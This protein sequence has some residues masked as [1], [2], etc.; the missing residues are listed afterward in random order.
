MRLYS[1][2]SSTDK[3]TLFQ[4]KNAINRS[5]VP[6]DPQKNVKATEDF[7]E[8]DLVG[9]IVAAAKEILATQQLMLQEVSHKIA[10]KFVRILCTEQ[11]VITDKKYLYAC[12][13]ITLGLLWY[14]YRDATR[15]GD[16][17]RIVLIW[18][19]LLMI[20][21]ACKRINYSKEAAILLFQNHFLFSERKAAQLKYS[22]FINVHGRPGCNISSDLFMEH[23][24]RQLKT[25]IAHMGSNVQPTSILNAAKA[26]GLV[27]KICSNFEKE[28]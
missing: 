25:V 13:L 1:D 24:N 6:T 5:S 4:L 11:E 22:H 21:H 12:E 15:E 8:L 26:I 19:F 16:G 7:L 2:K 9:H 27:H 10:N 14:G 20:F 28:I 23:L 17:E 3:G 18:K